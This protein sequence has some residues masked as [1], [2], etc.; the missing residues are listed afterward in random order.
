M[1]KFVI[2]LLGSDLEGGG[3][4]TAGQSAERVAKPRDRLW[5]ADENG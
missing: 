5:M 3:T 4:S 2:E 1:G